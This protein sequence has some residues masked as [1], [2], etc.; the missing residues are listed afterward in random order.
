M[1]SSLIPAAFLA[2]VCG[3]GHAPD[4]TATPA[5]ASAAPADPPVPPKP[6]RL[7]PDPLDPVLRKHAAQLLGN[8]GQT[9]EDASDALAEKKL[10][11]L[12]YL[13]EVLL[14]DAGEPRKRIVPLVVKAA[15]VRGPQGREFAPAATEI[16]LESLKHPS[17]ALRRGAAFELLMPATASAAPDA[18]IDALRAVVKDDADKAVREQAHKTL[19]FIAVDVITNRLLSQDVTVRDLDAHFRVLVRVGEPGVETLQKATDGI[20]RDLNEE[21]RL[22]QVRRALSGGISNPKSLRRIELYSAWSRGAEK[23][24]DRIR[25]AEKDKK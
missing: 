12:P 19:K 17:G 6:A 9:R 23:A 2:L 3:C 16:L 14:D 7:I 24:L 25:E 22:D 4:A 8:D 21:I 18:I 15:F 1:P 11:A 20:R 5:A 10:A 13:L